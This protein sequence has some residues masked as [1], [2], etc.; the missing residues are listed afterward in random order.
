MALLA[1]PAGCAT[2]YAYRFE[3]ADPGASQDTSSEQDTVEDGDVKANAQI[4]EN[5]VLLD[6]TNKTDAV[7]Q[8]RWNKITLDRGN[9][10][11]SSL[12]PDVDL[13]WIQP[14]ATVAARLVPLA[15]PRSGQHAATYEAR[16]FELDVPMVVRS[17]AKV[18]R[19][20][21]IAHVHAI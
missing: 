4:T 6:V 20:H 9:K 13:G 10:T 1:A 15:L 5:A 11:T 8:V 19:F 16:H 21:F 3:P 7:L 2:T 18:V 14:G 12:G 17:E